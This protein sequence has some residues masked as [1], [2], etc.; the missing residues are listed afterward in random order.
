MIIDFHTHVFPDKI[1][2]ATVGAL[3]RKG[4]TPA[5]SDGTVA[6]L[7]SQMKRSGVG[8]SVNLP[9]LTKPAQFDSILNFARSINDFYRDA[10]ADAPRIISFAGI[11]PDIEDCEEKLSLV[12]ESGILGI[13]IH[14]DYQG[15]FIDDERYVRI[16]A[17]AKRL[18]LITVTHAGLDGAYVGE[19]I[20]CTPTRVMRVLDK[21][22][23]YDRL[24]LAHMGANQLFS[25][26]YDILA[27]EDIYFDT[28][29]VLQ[30]F[31]E[32]DFKKMAEKHGYGKILFATDSPWRDLSVDTERI[33]S[34]FLSKADENKIFYENAKKLLMLKD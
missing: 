10:S 18:G 30:F 23:G 28:A 27:G 5:F 20:K 2:A 17:E 8:I 25:E 11:H 32:Y 1:A 33:R 12:K 14:P 6:G 24:V 3:E 31:S 16:L 34:Y 4:N 21:I 9:V 26:V 19:P 29:Y 13:K 22:G 7:V 15:T